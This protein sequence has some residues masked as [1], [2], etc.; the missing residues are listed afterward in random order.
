MEIK[1]EE[2][3]RFYCAAIYLDEWCIPLVLASYLNP[4]IFV[5]DIIKQMSD[6]HARHG[7]RLSFCLWCKE[8]E[9]ISNVLARPPKDVLRHSCSV[10]NSVL[11]RDCLLNRARALFV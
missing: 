8:A 10:S 11:L 9:K 5:D 6:L 4:E 1:G 2:M 3:T 7:Y